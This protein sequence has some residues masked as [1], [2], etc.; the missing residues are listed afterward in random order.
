MLT[1][2]FKHATINAFQEWFLGM[3]LLLYH[4]EKTM[5]I[6]GW[7]KGLLNSVVLG[8]FLIVGGVS[9]FIFLCH[10]LFGG[11][12]LLLGSGEPLL[13]VLMERMKDEDPAIRLAAVNYI[14]GEKPVPE[15]FHL[16]VN[17][18]ADP[19]KKV[20]EAAEKSLVRIGKDDKGTMAVK[21][22]VSIATKEELWPKAE[23]TLV[24]I[25]KPAVPALVEELKIQDKKAR[26]RVQQCLARI[27]RPAKDELEVA[28]KSN[29]PSLSV[30]ANEV[31]ERIP[32]LLPPRE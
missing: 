3:S 28:L 11:K 29:N 26:Q 2:Y 27:G 22:L 10:I 1:K 16:L 18:L 8:P 6:V 24:A 13:P 12:P 5:K 23:K 19:D 21:C 4:G 32:K 20:S 25:G 17:A 15:A 31:L 14:G 7:M 30:A 9:F